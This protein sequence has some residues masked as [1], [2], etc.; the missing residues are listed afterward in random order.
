MTRLC[1]F[2]NVLFKRLYALLGLFV[3]IRLC[4]ALKPSKLR[5]D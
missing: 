2:G 5:K 1:M 4:G 3:E